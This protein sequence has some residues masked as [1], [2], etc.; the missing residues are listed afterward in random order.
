M[1]KLFERLNAVALTLMLTVTVGCGIVG[2]GG[3]EAGSGDGET[4][5]SSG[6]GSGGAELAEGCVVPTDESIEAGEYTPLSRPLFIYVNKASLSKPNVKAFVEYY[7]NEGQALVS[8]VGYV[9]LSSAQ[10]EEA[11][12]A[13]SDAAEG[14]E[15][16]AEDKEAVV[17]IDGSSTVAPISQAMAEDIIQDKGIKVTVATSGTGGGFKKFIKGETDINDASRPIKDKEA[18]ACKEAGIEFIELKVAIDGL[19]VV[20]NAEND[21]CGCM[22]AEQLKKLWEPGSTIKKWNELDPSW[23]DEEI[24]LFGPDT[25]SGTFDYFTEVIIEPEDGGEKIRSDYTPAV[26]D[27]VLVNGVSGDKYALGY[28]GYAYYVENKDKLKALGIKPSAEE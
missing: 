18:A 22:S 7:L 6:E 10:L 27:T 2:C 4:S 20:V 17:K 1:V 26:Q 21:W 24:K 5:T 8:E 25:E 12:K 15:M 13:L 3:E 28:F 23:P 16:A 19:T 14:L 11:K 9:K